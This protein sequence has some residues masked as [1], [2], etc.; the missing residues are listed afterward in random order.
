M[1]T[2]NHELGA[3]FNRAIQKP[4]PNQIVASAL[5]VIATTAY[6]WLNPV[7]R[8]SRSSPD[9]RISSLHF[10]KPRSL[11]SV[12]N[13]PES[14]PHRHSPAR[15]TRI[16]TGSSNQDEGNHNF[17]A[18]PTWCTV[19]HIDLKKGSTMP[20][21][22]TTESSAAESTRTSVTFPTELYETLEAIAKEKKVTVA[23]VIRDAAE[24]YVG[25]QWPLFGQKAA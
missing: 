25:Q 5:A 7:G 19:V 3:F 14:R 24:K 18:T 13:L 21:S 1:S 16:L 12:A 9:W 23:W 20:T 11:T 22:I 6:H 2:G 15:R 8:P 10:P 17:T 4:A